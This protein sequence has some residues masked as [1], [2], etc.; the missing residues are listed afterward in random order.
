[1]MQTVV[2]VLARTGAFRP[3]TFPTGRDDISANALHVTDIHFA[4]PA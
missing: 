2:V 4:E 1:M 3:S